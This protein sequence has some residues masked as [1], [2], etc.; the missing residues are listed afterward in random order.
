[1]ESRL[2][3]LSWARDFSERMTPLAAQAT[4]YQ[5]GR[6]RMQCVKELL[7]LLILLMN[8]HE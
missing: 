2:T 5:M 8:I 3:R 6:C 7:M 1:M 4:V